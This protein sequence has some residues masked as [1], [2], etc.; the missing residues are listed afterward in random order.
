MV[1]LFRR[2]AGPFIDPSRGDAEAANLR[3]AAAAGEWRPAEAAL[4]A[5]TDPLRREFLIDA[6]ALDTS[7]LEWVDAWVR[8]R[9]DLQT[10]RTVWGACAAQFAFH[11]RTGAAPQNV[12]AEQWRGFHEWLGHAQEQL[13]HA[14]LMDPSDSAPWVALA[15]CAV[16]LEVPLGDAT[17]R[18]EGARRLNPQ[19]EL[20][21][22]AYTT[23]VSPRWNGTA[24]LMWK[25][26]H[27]LLADEPEGSP[28]W[29]LAPMG[30]FEQWVAE[31]M[32]RDSA[33][34]ASRYFEQ[35]H[36]QQEIR[37]AHR[38]YLGA[39]SRRP[40]PLESQNRELFAGAFYLMGA[41]DELR[42]ELEH[43][44]PGIQRLPWGYLGSSLA[45]YQNVREAAGLK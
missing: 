44:G 5:T 37:D 21:A 17:E 13:R 28:R 25:F 33:V 31:R 1:G 12:S 15:W 16:G 10:A 30:H 27:G 8:E 39:A 38:R 2:P 40:S 18:W 45:S 23:F 24:E 29:T 36:V 4:A 22:M 7:H 20:G 11:I 42:R 43:I 19:T 35:P 3:K 6:L 26:V 14:T 41:R 9:P 32:R 34:H